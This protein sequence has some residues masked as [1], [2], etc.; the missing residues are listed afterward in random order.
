MICES[1]REFCE[2]RHKPEIGVAQEI[3][4]TVIFAASTVG[5]IL[6][7]LTAFTQ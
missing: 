1:Y 4:R 2:G 5:L 3:I 6:L 7:V